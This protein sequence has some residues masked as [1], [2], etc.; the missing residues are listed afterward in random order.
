MLV[1]HLSYINFRKRSTCQYKILQ[2]LTL[3][4]S[5]SNM[6]CIFW[7][8]SSSMALPFWIFIIILAI[9]QVEEISEV[10]GVFDDIKGLD[11]VELSEEQRRKYRKVSWDYFC[12][13]TNQLKLQ[14][15]HWFFSLVRLCLIAAHGPISTPASSHNFLFPAYECLGIKVWSNSF[16]CLIPGFHTVGSRDNVFCHIAAT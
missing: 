9:L 13:S 8:C 3:V 15:C 7:I 16:F 1:D 5:L 14:T 10:D 12:S 2:E 11:E 4:F 6:T